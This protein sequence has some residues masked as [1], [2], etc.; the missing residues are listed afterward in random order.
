VPIYEFE[1][2]KCG[3]QFEK[4]QKL[5]DL[6]PA[7]CP[8][9]GAKK[10]SQ[11]LSAPAFQFKG[12]GWYVTDYAKKAPTEASSGVSSNGKNG[13]TESKSSDSA[14]TTP[15]PEKSSTEKKPDKTEKK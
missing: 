5:S 2:L 3:Y 4:L 9:C 1:C 7:Q 13:K 11:V 6:P 10:I 12:T 14:T 8:S 15:A